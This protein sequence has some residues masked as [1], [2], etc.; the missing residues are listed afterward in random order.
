MAGAVLLLG[1]ALAGCGGSES[2]GGG[3]TTA[4]AA[5]GT[6]DAPGTTTA[7]CE[8][9]ASGT[10]AIDVGGVERTYDV[11][12]PADD[13]AG[14]VPTLVLFH[15]FNSSKEEMAA[16]T[17]L[18]RQ[19]PDAGVL[20]IVPQGAGQPA[21]WNV[22][23]G[24]DQDRAFTDAMLAAERTGDCV[25]DGPLWLAGFSAGSAF[26]AV[27][28]CTNAASVTGLGLV[29]ALAPAVCPPDATPNVVITHGTADPAVPFAGGEQQVGET[30]VP[31]ASL[32]ES[33]ATWAE[34]AGCGAEPTTASIGSDVSVTQ[35]TGCGRGSTITFEVVD[36]GG[37]AWPGAVKPVALGRTTQTISSSCILLAAIADPA[38]DPLPD[39]PGDGPPPT[40]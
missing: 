6:T 15:G 12:P 5:A 37:H 18:D 39:C 21:G 38:L 8:L 22:L 23:A 19:A 24:F 1:A 31:L 27:Y 2:S 4:L 17:G 20:L 3:T 16:L 40:P 32:P 30:K 34:R 29:G 25:A 36:G 33:A 35:W 26:S 10:R 7:P 28:G 13:V 11:H 9:P 14:P